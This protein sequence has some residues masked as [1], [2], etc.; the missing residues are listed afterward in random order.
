MQ[1]WEKGSESICNLPLLLGV[2]SHFQ[3]LSC[4]YKSSTDR[5]KNIKQRQNT[6][7]KETG[8]IFIYFLKYKGSYTSG[9]AYPTSASVFPP[10]DFTQMTQ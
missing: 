6:F 5:S 7:H 2:S 9:H 3:I 10:N 4:I 1:S 8:E